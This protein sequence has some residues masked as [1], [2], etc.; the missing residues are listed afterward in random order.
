MGGCNIVLG[1]EWL[2]TL[3]PITMD[4]QEI[5]MSFVKE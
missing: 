1:V 4:F 3:G 5:Y 2:C